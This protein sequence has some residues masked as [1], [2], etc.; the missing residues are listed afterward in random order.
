M[1]SL[2]FVNPNTNKNINLFTDDV[3]ALLNNGYNIHDIIAK[4]YFLMIYYKIIYYIWM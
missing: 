1:Y 2:Q 3:M 4:M